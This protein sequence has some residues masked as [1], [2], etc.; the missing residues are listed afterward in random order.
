MEVRFWQLL[1]DGFMENHLLV[2]NEV[3]FAF[4]I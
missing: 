1:S 2:E 3:N 4:N